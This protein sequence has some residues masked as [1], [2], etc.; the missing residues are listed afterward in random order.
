MVL[1]EPREGIIVARGGAM[2]LGEA[3]WWQIELLIIFD[4]IN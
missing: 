4:K 2:M 1:E 3:Q